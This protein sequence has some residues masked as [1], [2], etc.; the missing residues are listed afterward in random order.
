[1]TSSSETSGSPPNSP[2]TLGS[3]VVSP[4][5]IAL[6]YRDA[7][8]ARNTWGRYNLAAQIDAQRGGFRDYLKA[9]G[10]EGRGAPGY[11]TE[12]SAFPRWVG[13]NKPY[14]VSAVQALHEMGL[15][16]S[17]DGPPFT[18]SNG[19]FLVNG[20]ED[21]TWDNPLSEA[22]ATLCLSQF[23]NGSL[24][25]SQRSSS[26]KLRL[27]GDTYRDGPLRELFKT[28]TGVD[29][30]EIDKKEDLEFDV[31]T[32]H[33]RFL[34]QV[35]SLVGDKI[36]SASVIHPLIVRALNSLEVDGNPI[37]AQPGKTVLRLFALLFVQGATLH[38]GSTFHRSLGALGSRD[39]SRERGLIGVRA[40]NASGLFPSEVGCL[41]P[42]KGQDGAGS[43]CVASMKELTP[44]D[45][46]SFANELSRRVAEM[47][48]QF[49]AARVPARD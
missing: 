23:L 5:D 36:K 33:S 27:K 40:L 11:T 39:L 29:P 3:L 19:M 38:S 6:T 13:G 7:T 14:P 21:F 17:S 43:Y 32:F 1:M 18:A 28:F 9:R 12:K 46:E 31:A 30:D 15:F 10:I 49:E 34:A 22:V 44:F 26:V 25:D 8:S 37:E 35:G 24:N 20:L 45:M 41:G 16:P 47:V 42:Y 2:E 48:A 4:S